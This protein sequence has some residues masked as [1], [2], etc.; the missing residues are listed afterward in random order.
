MIHFE[1]ENYA[2]SKW[3][4]RHQFQKIVVNNSKVIKNLLGILL[5]IFDCPKNDARVAKVLI[6]EVLVLNCEVSVFN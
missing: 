1:I 4:N 5:S 2:I 3:K 6:C